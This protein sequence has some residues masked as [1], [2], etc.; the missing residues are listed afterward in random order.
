MSIDAYSVSVPV[1]I[2]S[3][4]ALSRI[5][6]KA[7][8]W[9]AAR[10]ADP[11]VIGQTRFI[12]DMLPLTRQVQT[13][14]DF[15]KNATARLAGVDAPRFEDTEASLD[16]L[17]ARIART[18]EFLR[19]IDPAAIAAAPGRTVEFPVGPQKRARMEAANYLVHY[20][21]PNFHFHLTTAYAILRGIGVELGK[22]DYMGAVPGFEF[23]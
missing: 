7:S 23:V 6:D 3:L 22:M 13:A 10:R 18:L 16:D 20:A 8:A 9:A 21:L 4:E 2:R 11:V 5:L 14:C 12:P 1:F 19:S 15:A 17:K